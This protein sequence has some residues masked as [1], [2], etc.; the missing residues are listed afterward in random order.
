MGYE[1]LKYYGRNVPLTNNELIKDLLCNCHT[2]SRVYFPP[3]VNS[4]MINDIFLSLQ[5]QSQFNQHFRK[6]FPKPKTCTKNKL[7]F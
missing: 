5:F 3:T 4:Q 2:I 6:R 7:K 1:W